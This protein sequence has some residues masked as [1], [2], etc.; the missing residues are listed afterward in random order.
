MGWTNYHALLGS[1]WQVS[2]CACYGSQLIWS[3]RSL[4]QCMP[5]IIFLPFIQLHIFNHI[6][7]TNMD[8]VLLF[9]VFYTYFTILLD[10]FSLHNAA[11]KGYALSYLLASAGR[12]RFLL[13][14]PGMVALDLDATLKG[15]FQQVLHCLENVPKL[16]GENIPAATCNL[17]VINSICFIIICHFYL[18]HK[19][20]PHAKYKK[21]IKHIETLV[22][23]WYPEKNPI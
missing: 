14:T 16:H 10:N 19:V 5:D 9:L 17:S 23:S 6:Q 8:P 11:I 22:E 2:Y 4:Y 20:D 12:I 18:Y 21:G 1:M 3:C 13:G 15:L 7:C